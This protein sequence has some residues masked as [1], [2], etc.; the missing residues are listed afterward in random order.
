[1]RLL[2]TIR[3]LWR[4]VVRRGEVERSMHAEIRAYVDL[5]AAE[6]ERTGMPQAQARR[7][8]LVDTGGVE[9]VKEATRD[10]WVG[11]AIASGGR[12][13]RYALRTL[14]RSPVFL[15]VA[16]GV[17]GIGIGG[18]TAVFT[19]VNAAL[20]R[21]LPAVDDPGR[22]VTVERLQAANRIAEFSYPD[23]RDLAERNT[24]L[25]LA[26]YNGTSMALRDAHGSGRAW[27]G[28]VSDNFFSVLGVRP[29]IGQLFE[30]ADVKDA[31]ATQV[32]LGHALWQSRFAGSP[33]VVGSTLEL[34]GHAFTIVGVA[35]PGFI[36]AMKRNPMELW[37]PIVMGGRASPVAY[38]LDLSSRREA[39]LRLVGRLAPGKTVDDAQHD[40]AAIAAGLAAAYATNK[41]RS[42][43][44]VAGAGMT[45]EERV[46]ER[47]MPQ[48][49][50]MAVGLLLLIS[51]GNVAGLSLVRA[52]ARRRELATRLALG[53][54]RAALV[55]QTILEA[56]VL[57]C[58]AGLLGVAIAQALVHSAVIVRAV[59]SV[60]GLDLRADARVLGI[61]L[62]ASALT[63]VI[64]SLLPALQ[65]FQV[66]PAA[67]LKDGGGAVRRGSARGQRA[68][69]AAQVAASLVLLSA[70]AIVF[71]TFQRILAA[72]DDVDPGGLTFAMVATEAS[73]PDSARQLAFYR[74]LLSRAAAEPG[75]ARAALTS[76][77]PPLSWSMKA[78][79]FRHGD[80]PP[81]DA[82]VGREAELGLRAN[83][84]TASEGFF[85]V[86]RIPLLRGRTFNAWDDERSER[87]AIVSRRL[88]E[89]LWQG[90]DAIG[91]L[92]SWPS[93]EG[94]ARPPLR[95]VGLAADTRDVSLGAAPPA[96][97][98][99]WA[100]QAG[101]NLIL[102]LRGERDLP[103]EATVLHRLVAG[104]DPSVA[105]LG[106]RTLRQELRSQL[107]PQR[108][109]SAWIGVFGVVALL[110]AAIGLY[111]VLAQ[112]VLQRTRELAVRSALG[113]PPGGI[114]AMVLG[115]GMRLVAGG[116]VV[117]AVGSVAAFRALRALLL[118]VQVIDMRSAVL[119][120]LLLSIG[121]LVAAY[122]PARRA[123][124]LDPAAALRSD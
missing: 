39:W 13:L 102:I 66:S 59:V 78:S 27:V 72:H 96:M 93:V 91:Q 67:V 123:A 56:A 103:V 1:M 34:D 46:E 16:V 44:V 107:R 53:A 112:N 25:A 65:L 41:N 47:E 84:V 82:L 10:A 120:S 89:E 35:P 97:Y 111:G 64:V 28:Y 100:Q 108:A 124:H 29:V 81:R 69:V 115:D 14:R 79:V 87:V 6:Y 86:M 30:S 77:V 76:S 68:L 51:C 19:V 18:A 37:I 4:N 5:L 75:I 52:A 114:L 71:S 90:Q 83:A 88:A 48:L 113:A 119:A 121:M 32:V 20:L 21:P 31:S 106:A 99:P 2:V 73:I 22:L 98:V 62:I 36:G 7:Q 104:L 58:G 92:I 109:A 40:L 38:G 43:E 80:E 61:A 33:N 63:T 11:S 116:V 17:L 50:G 26:A 110:L 12:E 15:L 42:V 9:Q 3:S 122:V 70:A 85:D 54:S 101:A 49:L 23:F 94:P 45:A 117:G 95:V 8:A 57:A 55:R 24:T 118:G 60:P 105:V 74:A